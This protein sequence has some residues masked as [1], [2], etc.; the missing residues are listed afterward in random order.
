MPQ[1]QACQDGVAL[2]RQPCQREV[3]RETPCHRPL[4]LLQEVQG[5]GGRTQEGRTRQGLQVSDTLSLPI[6]ESDGMSRVKKGFL[7][8]W[9]NLNFYRVFTYN[10]LLWCHN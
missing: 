2:A 10:L 9:V 3:P 4:L 8:W 7:K 6:D 1:P 5:R